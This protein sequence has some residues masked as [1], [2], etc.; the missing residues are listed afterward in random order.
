M[1]NFIYTFYMYI[2]THIYILHIYIT[3]IHIYILLYIYVYRDIQKHTLIK[4]HAQNRFSFYY[5]FWCMSRLIY[6]HASDYTC[7]HC[8][9]MQV[10][11]KSTDYPERN[12]ERKLLL[13][14][15]KVTL[16]GLGV[17]NIQVVGQPAVPVMLRLPRLQR[18]D[19]LL[20]GFAIDNT[21]NKTQI[22]QK[23]S[24]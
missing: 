1:S 15:A 20:P 18:H 24:P 11:I 9:C 19:S 5:I 14:A 7:T 2:Y 21:T 17:A 10:H 13:S 22:S 12:I 16:Q 8:T 4:E 23:L 3:Y 6:I